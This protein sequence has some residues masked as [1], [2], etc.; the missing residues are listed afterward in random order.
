[1]AKDTSG[2]N[3]RRRRGSA[4]PR[5]DQKQRGPVRPY[6]HGAVREQLVAEALKLARSEGAPGVSL[7]E[8]ASRVGVSHA[9]VYH[10]FRNRVE[11]IAAAAT[12][13]MLRLARS[14]ERVEQRPAGT[15]TERVCR[16]GV[17]YVEFALTE[18]AAF[19]LMFATEV[20]H[21][22]QFPEL[23]AASD[24]AAAPLLRALRAWSGSASGATDVFVRE[25][26]LAIWALVHGLSVLALD[27][28]FD[29]GEL[30]ISSPNR[31]ASYREFARNAVE[32]HLDAAG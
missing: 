27:N 10:H 5:Q 26:G 14:L 28:Q 9:A 29:E 24:A 30:S 19:R 22:A 1:M 21:K 11:L 32:R 15:A 7:R 20:A 17:A 31:I 18:P 23:R 2:G 6:H 8:A 13:G 16:I 3:A 25:L 12:D 4:D